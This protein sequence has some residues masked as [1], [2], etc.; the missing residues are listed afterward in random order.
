MQHSFSIVSCQTSQLLFLLLLTAVWLTNDL[1][2]HDVAKTIPISW[3][4]SPLASNS[5]QEE[6]SVEQELLIHHRLS[7]DRKALTNK[8]TPYNVPHCINVAALFIYI[9]NL[10]IF[11]S[12]R[13][14]YS[15]KLPVRHIFV[16]ISCQGEQPSYSL[17]NVI[18][19]E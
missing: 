14:A 18:N 9:I 6:D 5:D 7:Q 13:W 12:V 11:K 15:K 4:S 17:S 16:N 19:A 1:L 3:S 8:V 10:P 2:K